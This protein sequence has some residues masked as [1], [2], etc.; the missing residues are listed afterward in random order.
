MLTIHKSLEI[1]DIEDFPLNLDKVKKKYHRKMKIWHPDLC[2]EEDK[3]LANNYAK[4][5]NNAFEII[6]ENIEL[7]NNNQLHEKDSF[8]SQTIYKPNHNYNNYSFTPGFP[9]EN[10]FEV[11]LKSS[12]IISAGYSYDD[13]TLYIKFSRGVY[14]YK[15]VPLDVWDAFIVADSN[16]KFAHRYIY[17]HY[18]YG[19]CTEP[20]RPFKPKNTLKDPDEDKTENYETSKDVKD[21]ERCCA[22][23]G[24]GI[25]SSNKTNYCNKNCERNDIYDK[26]HHRKL[27][28]KE[29]E[30]VKKKKEKKKFFNFW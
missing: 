2:K 11:F 17:R 7:I 16:G 3:T 25:D 20:N 6:S 23:C 14:W 24:M 4:D 26:E 9:D 27:K 12:H 28:E 21:N 30:K 29:K 1:L 5:I 13:K 18:Q 19:I 10:V 8:V 15:D 22:F